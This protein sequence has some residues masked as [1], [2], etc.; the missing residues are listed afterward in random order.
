MEIIPKN[1]Q[2]VNRG[3]QKLRD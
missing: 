3:R 2:C 1:A